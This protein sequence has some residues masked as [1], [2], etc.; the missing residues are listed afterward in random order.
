MLDEAEKDTQTLEALERAYKRFNEVSEEER[1]LRYKVS[2]LGNTEA[3]ADILGSISKQYDEL[4]NLKRL[5]VV[6]QTR[7]LSYE[8]AGRYVEKCNR[9]LEEGTGRTTGLPGKLPGA[10]VLVRK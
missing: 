7:Q 3:L 10:C 4:D 9:E 6:S 5:N 8:A 2:S 1:D